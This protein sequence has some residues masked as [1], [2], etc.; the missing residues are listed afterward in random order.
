M[1]CVD[2]HECDDVDVDAF[3]FSCTVEAPQVNFYL[4]RPKIVSPILVE[5]YLLD[6]KKIDIINQH[7]KQLGKSY[8]V[9]DLRR[10]RCDCI[11]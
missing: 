10:V 1:W 8:L 2:V 11:C 4:V 3:R 6:L 7:Q 5:A 9:M